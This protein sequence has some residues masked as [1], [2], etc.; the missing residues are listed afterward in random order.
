MDPNQ[1]YQQQQYGGQPYGQPPLPPGSKKPVGLYVV[2]AL[3][4]VA[5]I[6]LTTVLITK[7]VL[8][9]KKDGGETTAVTSTETTEAAASTDTQAPATDAAT[10][11]TETSTTEMNGA[12]DSDPSEA[13]AAYEQLLTESRTSGVVT[14]DKNGEP[15]QIAAID[16]SGTGADPGVDGWVMFNE[17]ATV[18]VDGDGRKELL[19]RYT[20]SPMAAMM[21][22]VFDYSKERGVYLEAQFFPGETYYDGW[23]TVDA[24]HNQGLAGSFWPYFMYRYVED[25]DCYELMY[26]VDA[27]DGNIFAEDWDGNPFPVADDKDGDKIIY[28]VRSFTDDNLNTTLEYTFD[29]KELS[30][31]RAQ[32]IKDGTG[33]AIGWKPLGN[34]EIV[35]D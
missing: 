7:S 13:Y 34:G 21:C 29:E 14:V 20:D 6:V 18:D 28:Y 27:W 1:Q 2:I 25:E 19:A 8:G 4:A 15:Y 11:A 32:Y 26:S 33:M 9:G 3:L 17:Y 31:W 24:S 10:E 5:V 30:E 23:I 35:F 12:P 22:C 16:A